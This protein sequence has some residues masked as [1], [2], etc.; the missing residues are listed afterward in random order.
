VTSVRKKQLEK[1]FGR[2]F[3]VQALLNLK[4]INV[5]STLFYLHRGLSLSDLFYLSII[6]GLAS[7]LFEIPSSY[8]ADKWGRKR[9]IIFGISLALIHWILFIFADNFIIFAIA[10][11]LSSIQW[12]CFSGTDDAVIYDTNR[13]L[14]RKENSLMRLGQYYSARSVLKIF[15]PLIGVVIAHNLLEW[16]FLLI[17]FVDILAVLLALWFAFQITEPDHH[18]DVAERE[19]GIF[20]DAFK[21]VRSDRQIFKAMVGRALVFMASFIIWRFH[22]KFFV[23]LGLMVVWLGI[24]W[25]VIHL[26]LFVYNRRIERFTSL[27]L[28]NERINFFNILVLAC[29]SFFITILWLELNVY[30]LLLFYTFIIIFEAMRWPLY[31]E[32]YNRRSKSFN[33]AT[34]LS[35]ANFIKSLLDPVVLLM[36]AL[37]ID[38]NINYPFILTLV[39]VLVAV[40]FFRLPAS[41]MEK[42]VI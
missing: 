34:T 29:L 16:Q 7:L 17:I 22:Q 33:R 1:N 10:L 26:I 14:G 35:L 19:A 25:S 38:K 41:K 37:L 20:R 5:I 2:M 13:E 8:M 12:A 32:F 18:M 24:T 6:W 4:V 21:L 23:D 40:L 15:A 36:A 9:T 42:T 3:W 39:M 28:I 27:K 30:L 31:A 11:I